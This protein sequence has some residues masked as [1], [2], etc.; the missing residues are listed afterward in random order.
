M[1]GV[2]KNEPWIIE[3]RKE[4]ARRVKDESKRRRKKGKEN[5][6][7]RAIN[8]WLSNRHNAMPLIPLCHNFAYALLVP[9]FISSTWAFPRNPARS[10][11]FSLSNK[12]D[13]SM[14]KLVTSARSGNSNETQVFFSLPSPSSLLGMSRTH[15]NNFRDSKPPKNH[16]KSTGWPKDPQ[17][18][19]LPDVPNMTNSQLGL[20]SSNK[21]STS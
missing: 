3:W 5:E 9:S 8:H 15:V 6:P 7:R 16:K 20:V 21:R 17:L 13:S 10:W 18:T 2:D 19:W 14:R 1:N 4:F 11:F 12:P